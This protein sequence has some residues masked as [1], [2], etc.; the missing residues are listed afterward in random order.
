MS[1]R[2]GL[3]ELEKRETS[4][5]CPIRTPSCPGRNTAITVN[6]FTCALNILIKTPARDFLKTSACCLIPTLLPDLII[7]SPRRRICN[8]DGLLFKRTETT[9]FSSYLFHRTIFSASCLR[10][11]YSR[12]ATKKATT[13]YRC[14]LYPALNFASADTQ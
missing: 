11:L 8:F 4:C 12:T 2:V 14:F 5:P 6:Y 10:R 3:D 7:D 13:Q 1:S 9:V